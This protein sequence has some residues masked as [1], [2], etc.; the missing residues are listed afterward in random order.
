MEGGVFLD[1]FSGTG[2]IP[3]EAWLVGAKVVAADQTER[4]VRGALQNMKHFAQDWLG[5]VRADATCS[6]TRRVDAVATDI[7]Y[8]RASSTRGR[9]PAE[10]VDDVLPK[11]AGVMSKGSFIALMHPQSLQVSGS[12][13]LSVLEEHHLY[14]HKLLTRTITVLDSR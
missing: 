8:G 6:P 12:R 13:E 3:L 5:V 14:V 1:P 2:S 11:L 4:M 9:A 7:P 10:V